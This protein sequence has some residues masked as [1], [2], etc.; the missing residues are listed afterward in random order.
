MILD[1]SI[2][3]W[4]VQMVRL[5]DLGMPVNELKLKYDI[6]TDYYNIYWSQYIF[7]G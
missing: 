3:Q 5:N 4:K 2:S 1:D 7:K 6:V